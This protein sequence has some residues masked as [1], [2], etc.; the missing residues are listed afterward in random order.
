MYYPNYS[1]VGHVVSGSLISSCVQDTGTYF[2][3]HENLCIAFVNTNRSTTSSAN[4]NAT[5][6]TPLY[7]GAIA[8]I[9]IG[10]IFGAIL[11]GLAIWGIIQYIKKKK[12][13]DMQ[14]P[15]TILA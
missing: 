1:C 5:F 10:C 12:E 4:V 14:Q 8:G 3:Q 9:V 7:A 2:K 13:Q 11:I 15:T 6:N